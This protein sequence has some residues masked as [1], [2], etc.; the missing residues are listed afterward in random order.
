MTRQSRA[1]LCLCFCLISIGC[2][3]LT[4]YHTGLATVI[5]TISGLGA[6]IVP[7]I[8]EKQ[9][10]SSAGRWP[11]S[12]GYVAYLVSF[13]I[14]T[15]WVTNIFR[16]HIASSPIGQ[17]T[18]ML[19]VLREMCDRYIAHQPVYTPISDIYGM[20]IQVVYLPGFF[21]PF[22]I[23]V[24]LHIDMRWISLF[25]FAG[26][27][28]SL[29]VVRRPAL[30]LG[31]I[32]I[33]IAAAAFTYL[34]TGGAAFYFMHTQEAIVL[35]YVGVLAWALINE[36]WFAAGIAAATCL[37]SRY[38]IF[39]PLSAGLV[40]LYVY[41]RAAAYRAAA[42]LIAGVLVLLSVSR[43]WSDLPHFIRIPLLYKDLLTDD[44]SISVFRHI[45][46]GSVG[47]AWFC[48]QRT[49][50]IVRGFNLAIIL[51]VPLA[52]FAMAG[53]YLRAVPPGIVI[54]CGLQIFLVCFLTTLS[55]P[56]GYVLYTSAFLS[57]FMI[58]ASL[59][60]RKSK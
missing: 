34:L 15:N 49:L 44:K 28:F 14:I 48:G 25:A 10:T 51:L 38:F 31:H 40:W 20:P 7:L 39:I 29:V 50:H 2:L 42:G 54:L 13:I 56:F 12:A 11:V 58:K 53:R 3:L 59:E 8:R 32:S 16:V 36:Y 41:D 57:I 22:S 24:A 52:Y 37:M 23:P 9:E 19:L 27:I 35:L 30:T 33:V 45:Y 4:R 6:G 55:L 17:M 60:A 46:Q 21:L 26:A 1:L 47:F 18:D 43:T 5:F